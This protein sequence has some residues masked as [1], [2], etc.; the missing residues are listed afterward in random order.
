MR[1]IGLQKKIGTGGKGKQGKMGSLRKE[2]LEQERAGINARAE[3]TQKQMEEARL[4]EKWDLFDELDKELEILKRK[5]KHV[6][7]RLG[8]YNFKEDEVVE[9]EPGRFMPASQYYWL[10]DD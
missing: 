10:I 2:K 8:R 6:L 7:Y 4:T 5:Q 9:Y 3:E 1:S